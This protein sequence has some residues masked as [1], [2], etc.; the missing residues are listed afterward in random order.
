[1]ARV[2][3]RQLPVEWQ[4]E[5]PSRQLR[6]E[7]KPLRD[8]AWMGTTFSYWEGPI[9]LSGSQQGVGYLEMTGY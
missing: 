2:A 4:L 7:T 3:G 5:I 6:I 8:D 1:A 9:S